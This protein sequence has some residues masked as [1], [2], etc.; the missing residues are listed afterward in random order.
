[1]EI[2]KIFLEKNKEKPFWD[3][4]REFKKENSIKYCIDNK[5]FLVSSIIEY[6]QALEDDAYQE[7]N[8]Y[9]SK[10]K[11]DITLNNEVV[12]QIRAGIHHKCECGGNLRWIEQY[13]FVGCADYFNSTKTHTRLRYKEYIPIKFSYRYSKNYLSDFKKCY[14]LPEYLMVSVLFSFLYRVWDL[15][16]LAEINEEYFMTGKKNA[17]RSKTEEA[18]IEQMLRSIYPKV[19]YQPNFTV[20]YADGRKDLK[21]PDFLCGNLSSVL[22]VEVKKTTYLADQDKLDLYTHIV[23]KY[24]QFEGDSRILNACTIFYERLSTDKPDTS[25]LFHVSQISKYLPL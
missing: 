1:M 2:Q 5:D 18:V 22:I 4:L 20:V 25:T 21:I 8:N 13:Q 19:V 15:Q 9:E 17:D 3:T 16:P 23:N 7:W 12:S 14:N 10:R 24:K 6:A 11:K